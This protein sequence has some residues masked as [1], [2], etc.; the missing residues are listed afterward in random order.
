MIVSLIFANS[1]KVSRLISPDSVNGMD[2]DDECRLAFCELRHGYL[3]V[4][5]INKASSRSS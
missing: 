1:Q 4:V 2:N 5:V 3:M